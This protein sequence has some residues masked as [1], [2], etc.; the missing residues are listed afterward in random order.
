MRIEHNCAEVNQNA[1]TSLNYIEEADRHSTCS[2]MRIVPRCGLL[3][4]GNFEV[5]RDLRLDF[6][7][8][9]IQ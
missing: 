5:D 7:R 6:D 9:A 4:A 8:L 2:A 3:L 1:Q